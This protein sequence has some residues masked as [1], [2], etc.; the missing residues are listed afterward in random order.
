MGDVELD[1]LV[2][3]ADELPALDELPAV[4]S[5]RPPDFLSAS[6]RR[7]YAGFRVEK[8]RREWLLGRWTAK[9]LLRRQPA[10][11]T[12]P[13]HAIVVANDPDGAPYFSIEHGRLPLSLSVSHREDKSF[14]ALSVEYIVG[15]DVERVEPRAAAFVE[16]FF[17]VGEVARVRAGPESLRDL[18]IAVIWSAKE[19][20]LK[21]LR[22][23]LRV[24]TRRV[25]IGRV[26]GISMPGQ[27]PDVKRRLGGL[28]SHASRFTEWHPVQVACTLPGAPTFKAWWRPH[29]EDVLTLAVKECLSQP[30]ISGVPR[31]GDDTHGASPGIALRAD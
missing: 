28:T 17:T 29:G 12:T 20:V 7:I 23:G 5:P 30:Q 6:E 8:R 4:G 11:G 15:A 10:Y 25:E 1:A 13:L 19:S 21:A 24:D 22:E 16:D 3:S 26:E 18:L 2:C 27:I 31:L 14:C 9:H